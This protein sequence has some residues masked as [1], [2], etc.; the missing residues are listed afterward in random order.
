MELLDLPNEL[1]IRIIKLIPRLHPRPTIGSLLCE[2]ALEQHSALPRI[3]RVNR[4]LREITVKLWTK[5]RCVT[6]PIDGFG[7]GNLKRF[8]EWRDEIHRYYPGTNLVRVE[9]AI[10]KNVGHD[11]DRQEFNKFHSHEYL[12]KPDCLRWLEEFYVNDVAGLFL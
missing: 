11:Q 10:I 3:M 1:L 8:C 6:L 12:P 2:E 5:S 9:V 7:F 4:R